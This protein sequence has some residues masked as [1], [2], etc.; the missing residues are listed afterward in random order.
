MGRRGE[1]E[2]VGRLVRDQLSHSSLVRWLWLGA[3]SG[4]PAQVHVRI[5]MQPLATLEAAPPW[6]RGYRG[7]FVPPQ[8]RNLRW[9]SARTTVEAGGGDERERGRKIGETRRNDEDDRKGGR[10]RT[11]SGPSRNSTLNCSKVTMKRYRREGT[12]RSVV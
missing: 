2:G 4:A 8:K 5:A 1:R 7:A 11:R 3:M 10:I 6:A 12:T 9:W